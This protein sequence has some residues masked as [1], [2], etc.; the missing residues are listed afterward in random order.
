MDGSYLMSGSW[1]QGPGQVGQIRSGRVIG[2]TVL[3]SYTMPWVAT[4]GSA[5]LTISPDR[6]RL[7]GTWKQKDGQGTWTMSR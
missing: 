2:N 4:T 5:K 7:Y 3:F 1:N 6:R